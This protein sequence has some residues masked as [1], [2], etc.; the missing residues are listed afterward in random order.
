MGLVLPLA[1]ALSAFL[2]LNV[3]ANNSGV[4]F[5]AAYGAGARTKKEA[6]ILI[7]IFVLLGAIISGAPVI[8]T[9]GKSIVPD[10]VLSSQM[11]LVLIVLLIS[12][13]FITWANILKIPVA[14]T[15]AIVCA[16]AGVGLYMKAL[17]TDKLLEVVG[18]WV[19]TPLIAFTINFLLGKY[20]YFKTLKFLTDRYSEGSIFKIFSIFLT[21]SGAFVAF[22]AGA[23][24]SANAA[25]PLVGMGLMT[26][27]TG[28]LL[29]G[30]G[31]SIGALLFGGRVLETVGK[32]IAEICI[33]RAVSVE[34]IAGTLILLASIKGI[35][36]SL[37]EIITSGIIGFSCALHG[38]KETFD[39]KHVIRIGFFWLVVPFIAIGV[40]FA[41]CAAYFKFGLPEALGF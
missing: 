27:T 33:L 31:M 8:E 24:N 29:A 39:N 20:L 37:A 25:G 35:P 30:I 12:I 21:I 34:L 26:S 19:V 36:V 38:F 4:S 10:T 28:A 22:S 6:L 2:A 17:D 41:L 11:G 5:G 16:I 7:S 14:T 13:F 9:M 18:W 23:N 1:L 3:G 32:E 40:S 15:H